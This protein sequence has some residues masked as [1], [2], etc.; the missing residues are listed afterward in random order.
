MFELEGSAEHVNVPR[1]KASEKL[2]LEDV[3]SGDL[4]VRGGNGRGVVR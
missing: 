1:R 2:D 3:R 4:S